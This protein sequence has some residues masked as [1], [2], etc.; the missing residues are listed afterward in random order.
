MADDFRLGEHDAL[1]TQ[2]LRRMDQM[3]ADVSEI[4][5]TLARQRGARSAVL[6][7]TATFCS[8]LGSLLT[9]VARYAVGT[10]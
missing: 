6:W 1:I 7:G 10:K 2:L 5:L 9:L 3:Q 8:V 4:K